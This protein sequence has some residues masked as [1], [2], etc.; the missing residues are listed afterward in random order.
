MHTNNILNV[1]VYFI[2]WYN[3]IVLR[4]IKKIALYSV[5]SDARMI[6]KAQLLSAAGFETNS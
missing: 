3:L 6:K 5:S 4:K 1:F 2:E